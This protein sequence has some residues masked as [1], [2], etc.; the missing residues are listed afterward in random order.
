MKQP[1]LGIFD[2]GTGGYIFTEALQEQFPQ[3]QF[4]FIADTENAPFGN[5]NKKQLIKIGQNLIN[6]LVAKQVDQIVVACHTICSN[7]FEQ[8]QQNNQINLISVNE[9]LLQAIIQQKPTKLAVLATEA[10]SKSEWFPT[11]IKQK[12]SQAEAFHLACPQLATGIDQ[13]D[14]KLIKLELARCQQNLPPDLDLIALACTH[15]PAISHHLQRM[16]PQAKIIDARQPLINKLRQ[17]NTS[18]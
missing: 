3:W 14:E 12:I 7:V 8:L 15:Y 18:K 4:S 2:S 13:Q 16:Y 11:R 5:K 10:T 17:E 9:L 1:H 6:Q